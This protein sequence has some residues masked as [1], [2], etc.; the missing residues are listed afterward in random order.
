M[1]LS[2]H[3]IRR[4]DGE[5]ARAAVPH[6]AAILRACVEGGASV[7]FM[8]PLASAKATE[9]WEGVAAEVAAR[10]RLLFL[11]ERGGAA[12]GTVQLVPAS[13]ENQPHRAE[14]AKLLV[15]PAAR[16]AGVAAALMQAAEA[17]AL[18]MGR[19]LLFLDT[20]ADSAAD[21]LYRRL[22]WVPVGVV[23]RYALMPDGAPCPAM[24]F[25][26]DLAA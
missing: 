12:L 21:R 25:Y 4:L 5:G 7:G 24:F 17:A 15:H 13:Q 1:S 3:H 6:L 10:R 19:T 22:G 14:I 8:A 20:E 2:P 16:R 9:F 18:A 11:A 23:P 26:R